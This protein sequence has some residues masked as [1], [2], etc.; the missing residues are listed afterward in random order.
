MRFPGSFRGDSDYDLTGP[1]RRLELM[2]NRIEDNF[3]GDEAE[4][5]ALNEAKEATA[6]QKRAARRARARAHAAQR[7]AL[8]ERLHNW[9]VR[10]FSR[11]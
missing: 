9:W 4:W 1:N 6:E 8:T 10:R 2:R 3:S 5:E 7:P 11:G